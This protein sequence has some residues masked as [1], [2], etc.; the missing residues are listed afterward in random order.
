M[1]NLSPYLLFAGFC[2]ST[3]ELQEPLEANNSLR[4]VFPNVPHPW[5][6]RPAYGG[7]R[8]LQELLR[9]VR[10]VFPEWELPSPCKRTKP[11]PGIFPLVGRGIL[12]NLCP[13]YLWLAPEVEDPPGHWRRVPILQRS[14]C[15]CEWRHTPCRIWYLPERCQV[16]PRDNPP[17]DATRRP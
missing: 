11:I 10:S 6:C 14:V 3:Y 1:W 5:S 15:H 4:D 9:R 12:T 7:Q 8:T 17:H 16:E 2:K 13:S